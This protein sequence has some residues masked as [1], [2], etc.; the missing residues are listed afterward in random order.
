MPG[1]AVAAVCTDVHVRAYCI[2]EKLECQRKEDRRA[3]DI[4]GEDSQGGCLAHIRMDELGGGK[5]RREKRFACLFPGLD[6]VE[7]PGQYTRLPLVVA[8][9]AARE[10]YVAEPSLQPT[11]VH[12]SQR[13]FGRVGHHSRSPINAEYA[14]Y[15][16]AAI[17]AERPVAAGSHSVRTAS[18]YGLRPG[19]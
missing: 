13:K 19:R 14:R 8:E 4:S 3:G 6:L 18:A 1:R 9:D 11:S 5:V 16:A 10:Q 2:S 12:E 17:V 15:D 7:I